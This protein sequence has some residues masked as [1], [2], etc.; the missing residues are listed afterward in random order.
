LETFAGALTRAEPELRDTRAL[1]R[2]PR[3]PLNGLLGVLLN[4]CAVVVAVAEIALIIMVPSR[5]T[6]GPP[7]EGLVEVLGNSLAIVS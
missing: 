7:L 5:C 3:I 6:L 2:A 4:V 1:L